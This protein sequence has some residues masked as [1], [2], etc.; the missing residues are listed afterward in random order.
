MVR[1][2]LG[3]VDTLAVMPTGAGKS[4]TYQLAA[5][6][7]PSPTL[8]LSPLIALMKDQVDKLP[9]AH[10]RDRDVRQ[11]VAR[12]RG[13]GGAPL[14]GRR[15][16]D[17]APVRGAR[18]A[19]AGVV[20]ADAPLDRRRPRRDRR[21][22]LRL[23]VGPRLPAR[24]PLHPPRARRARRAVGARDDGDRDA[25]ERGGDRRL[26]RASL[27]DGADERPSAEPPLRRR[28]RR[29]R[30]GAAARPAAPAAGARRGRRHRLRA[31]APLLRGDRA[32]P[33]R[34][35]DRRRALPRGSRAGG[36]HARPGVVRRG[37]DTGGRRDHR[38]RD[39]HRQGERPARGARQPPGLARELCADDRPR[40]TGRPSERHRALRR[41]RRRDRASPLRARR[42]ADARPPPPRLPRGARRPEG[43]SRRTRS[44]RRSAARTTRACSSGCSSRRASCAAGTTPGGRCGSSCCPSRPA[45]GARWTRSSTATRVRRPAGRAHRRVR[46]RRALPSPAGGGALRRDARRALRCVRRLRAESRRRRER[47]SRRASASRRSRG[48]DRRR[49]RGADVAPRPPQPRRDAPRVREGAAL[50]AALALPSARSRPLPSR[51]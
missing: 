22:A 37:A 32:H 9:P 13:G 50:C 36:A 12:P 14:V 38:V 19:A 34:S 41:A 8:V 27:R 5:M 28:A 33:A 6:L 18:A 11:L 46:R 43:P 39:G 3:G 35:R 16:R 20:R 44:T 4:L 17:A 42:R 31:L 7:R 51:R 2:A 21:G 10:R 24:L 23:D 30:R 48:R 15:R 29:Q 45:R 1:A 49:G 25:G 26:P 47:C 40:G